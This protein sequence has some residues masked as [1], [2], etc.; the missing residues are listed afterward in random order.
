MYRKEGNINYV[1]LVPILKTTLAQ[2]LVWHIRSNKLTDKIMSF[3][4]REQLEKGH[5]QMFRMR[6]V[7]KD[8][9]EIAK[10]EKLP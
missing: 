1:E 3:G 2:A 10:K 7:R 5:R 8:N 4:D 6:L 9:R